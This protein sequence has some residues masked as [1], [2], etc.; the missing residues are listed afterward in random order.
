MKILLELCH[1]T[2][3]SPLNFGSHQDLY[4]DVGIFKGLFTIVA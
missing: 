2:M 1:W 3:K 4:P